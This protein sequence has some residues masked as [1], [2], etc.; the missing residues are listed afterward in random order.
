M[1]ST[2]AN[3]V[4]GRKNIVMMA[5]VFIEVLSLLI[6][7]AIICDCLA[8]LRESWA[9]VLVAARSCRMDSPLAI[10]SLSL[11]ERMLLKSKPSIVSALLS[12]FNTNLCKDR[13]S[14]AIFVIAKAA[15]GALEHEQWQL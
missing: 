14:D 8:I 3:E 5:I 10:S 15:S 9:S 4:A 13:K 6:S 2:A 1:L 11:T 7:M 12:S